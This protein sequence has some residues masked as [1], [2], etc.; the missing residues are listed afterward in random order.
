VFMHLSLLSEVTHLLGNQ[1]LPCCLPIILD[2]PLVLLGRGDPFQLAGEFVV[3]H[4]NVR[5]L[6]LSISQFVL[7]GL[8]GPCS[9][10]VLLLQQ[11]LALF[12][13]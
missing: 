9:A 1:L 3:E 10:D 11:N 13:S 2:H 5:D 12:I 4:F 6:H 7:L 8:S